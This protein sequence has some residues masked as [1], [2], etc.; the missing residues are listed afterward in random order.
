M[1]ASNHNT[2]PLQQRAQI[3]KMVYWEGPQTACW[4]DQRRVYHHQSS[5]CILC[6][7]C[8][9]HA[10]SQCLWWWPAWRTHSGNQ[11][12]KSSKP[13][14]GQRVQA[15][16]ATCTGPGGPSREHHY[17]IKM[18]LGW[19]QALHSPPKRSL[20][21][22]CLVCTSVHSARQVEVCRPL[23]VQAAAWRKSRRQQMRQKQTKEIKERDGGNGLQPKLWG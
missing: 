6:G 4:R 16:P 22:N 8:N 10:P 15:G 17:A 12:Q 14:N 9:V 18:A 5:W 13:A 2:R 21:E 20:R 23:Q 19:Q 11:C 3:K 7:H 1:R